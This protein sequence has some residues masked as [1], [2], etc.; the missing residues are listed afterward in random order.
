MQI[1][2]SRLLQ[3]IKEELARYSANAS[4]ESLEE[5]LLN[6]IT[7]QEMV[8]TLDF[9]VADISDEGKDTWSKL[10]ISSIDDLKAAREEYRGKTMRSVPKG[11]EPPKDPGS[12]EAAIAD[13]ERTEKAKA[14]SAAKWAE[15]NKE[16]NDLALKAK[17]DPAALEELA[18][19]FFK[20]E[21]DNKSRMEKLVASKTKGGKSR[22]RQNIAASFRR[23]PANEGEEVIKDIAGKLGEKFKK[24]VDDFNPE[25]GNFISP[26]HAAASRDLI[27]YFRKG[28]KKSGS[29][30]MAAQRL[31]GKE[32]EFETQAEMEARLIQGADQGFEIMPAGFPDPLQALMT[33]QN[34]NNVRRVVKKLY[35]DG[36]LDDAGAYILNRRYLEGATQAQIADELNISQP[37]VAQRLNTIKERFAIAFKNFVK[38]KNK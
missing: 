32:G 31:K 29:D 1:K 36:K 34:I 30:P 20:K 18:A 6:E 7:D 15:K 19:Y 16:L 35:E 24:F 37:A 12:L 2:K 21:G 8:D 17:E 4:H 3:I 27:D 28:G 26:L 5:A 33:K 38:Q 22:A 14:K 13:A 25:E 23:M 10:E 11:S 9:Y